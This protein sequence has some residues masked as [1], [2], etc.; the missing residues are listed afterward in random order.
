MAQK[1][2]KNRCYSLSESADFRFASTVC[3]K[4]DGE[5]HLL[6]VSEKLS[7]SPDRYTASFAARNHKMREKNAKRTKLSA[8]KCR[9]NI[10]AKE[11]ENLR[12]KKEKN[13]D[14]S[15]QSNYGFEMDE[16]TTDLPLQ[17]ELLSE[18]ET[19]KK[20]FVSCKDF[21]IIYFD[22]E[23]SGFEKNSD[24]LQIAA[25][26]RDHTFN[27]YVKP[28]Q[29]IKPMASQVTG[30]QQKEGILYL[31]GQVVNCLPLKEALQLF[32]QFLNQ[33]EKPLLLVAHNAP[34]DIRHL[35]AAIL[36]TSMVNKFQKIVGFVD[37]L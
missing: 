6:N 26:F 10:L 32:L 18:L 37:T 23:T 17:S 21:S 22:L 31:R 13:E 30:L 29:S 19:I 34:F 35:L 28:T 36:S 9:R 20:N 3:S 27:V 14:M 15:Y 16:K 1:A 12:K 5:K 24:T 8:T 11:R 7:L 33:S 4:N 25:I 2:P